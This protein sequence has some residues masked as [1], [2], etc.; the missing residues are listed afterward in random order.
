MNQ[1]TKPPKGPLRTWWSNRNYR[2]AFL[3]AL[4]S[5]IWMASGLLRDDQPPVAA[6]AV[7]AEERKPLVKARYIDARLYH[8]QVRVRARTEARRSVSLRAEQSGRVED[9][10]VDEGATVAAADAI[11]QL[12]TEDKALLLQ[13]AESRLAQM[14]L[15]YDGAL[16]LQRDGYQSETAIASARNNLDSARA[17]LERARIDLANTRITAPF[18]GVVDR[19]TVEVG[20]FM[21]RGDECALL[22][23]MDPLVIAGRVSEAEVQLLQ[24]GQAARGYLLDGSEMEGIITRVGYSPDA[25]TRTFPVEVEVANPDNRL[26]I[27]LTTDL[28]I[29]APAQWAQL[30]PPSLLSLDDEGKL[31]VRIL[32]GDR[33]VAFVNVELVG[34]HDSGVWVTGLPRHALLVTVGQ[35]YVVHGELVD[36]VIEAPEGEQRS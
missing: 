28:L 5:V 15:E 35:E 4:V 2:L 7:P 3:I 29:D 1:S 23:D 9:L 11:C 36:V 13:Q 27:G 34:D 16:R 20:D 8:P 26:R 30:I 22:L 10:V 21:Q 24:I 14:Q 25:V 17:A 6:A 12:A 18:A 33:R 19:L 31:G 32:T